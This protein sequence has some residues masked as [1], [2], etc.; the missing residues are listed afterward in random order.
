[1]RVL[2]IF[3]PLSGMG[4]IKNQLLGIINR[5]SEAGYDL[6]VYASQ[7]H[8]DAYNLTKNRGADFSLVVCAGGDGT[9]NEVINGIMTLK[10]KPMLG[11]IPAG[12]TNDYAASLKLP[13]NMIK[14]SEL[15]V[16]GATSS[17]DVGYFNDKYFI[18]VAAFGAFTSVSY[19][20]PQESKNLIGHLA[21]VFEG[22]KTVGSIKEYH[23]KVICD[24][25]QFDETFVYGM[26][27]NT[28]SVG[29]IYKLSSQ[30]VELNDGLFEVM[31]IKAPK[32]AIDLSSITSFL[33]GIETHSPF[34]EVVKT[35]RIQFIADDEIP[36]T[37]DG[38]FGGNQKQV[39]IIN[40]KQAI[41]IIDHYKEKA[42]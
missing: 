2:F 37:L 13:K 11:Y 5:F 18:Y 16:N 42:V 35:S 6:T 27:T 38:E 14:A 40:K 1:M 17:F 39:D 15:I 41:N 30:D 3:N 20:T 23:M 9:L 10:E 31:L 24:D 22:I 7:A 33:L 12:S 19:N 8:L 34:V 4:Q 25:Q 32:T 36:W 21:Y 29:G 26:V 28:L